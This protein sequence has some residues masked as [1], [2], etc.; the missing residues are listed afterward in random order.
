MT[1]GKRAA[2]EAGVATLEAVLVFPVVLLLLMVI[3][4]FALWYHASDLASAAAQD[5]ARA[6]R[7]E[8]GTAAD[9][10]D[11]ANALLDQT[12]PTILQHRRVLVARDTTSTRVEV[13]GTCIPLVPWL[14][15]PIH[16]VAES[17]TERF[18]GRGGR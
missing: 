3:F 2:A 14:R 4:Q 12:G 11:R 5:G 7:V 10:R 15:L 8:G 18:V 1:L 17:S 16:A 6:S 9:G 13:K